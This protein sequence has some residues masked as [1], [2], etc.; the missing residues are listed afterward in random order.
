MI[1]ERCNDKGG[2]NLF[3]NIWEK[4]SL[5]FCHR[6]IHK[7]CKEKHSDCGIRNKRRGIA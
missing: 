7:S 1:K 6:T 5:A 3:L 2:Q 4:F